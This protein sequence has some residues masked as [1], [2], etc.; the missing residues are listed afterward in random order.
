MKHR[1]S[2]VPLLFVLLALSAC[3][4]QT[5]AVDAVS[6]NDR[7]VDLQSQ[8]VDEFDRFVG[9]MESYDSLGAMNAREVALDTAVVVA[10][11]LETM[12][13]FDKSTDLRDAVLNLVNL[14]K[15]GLETDISN[16]MPIIVSHHSTLSQLEMADSVRMAFSMEEDK[17]FEVVVQAQLAFAK[18]QKFEVSTP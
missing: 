10:K 14:Y 16:V 11:A 4:R 6:Y 15:R 8:V 7:I 9:A 5:N 1:V 3:N 18:A 2:L 17:L 12:P 13:A